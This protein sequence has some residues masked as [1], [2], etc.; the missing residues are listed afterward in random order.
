MRKIIRLFD[1]TLELHLRAHQAR[2]DLCLTRDQQEKK[3]EGLMN[4]AYEKE[5]KLFLA[6]RKATKQ[7]KAKAVSSQ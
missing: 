5:K 4:K 3:Y 6:I 2:E 7:K 1:S